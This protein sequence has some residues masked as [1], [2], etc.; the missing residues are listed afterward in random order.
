MISKVVGDYTMTASK[1]LQIETGLIHY[2]CD[3]ESWNEAL[4]FG[5][6]PRV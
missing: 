5:V 4:N 1:N 6:Y 2:G 3:D